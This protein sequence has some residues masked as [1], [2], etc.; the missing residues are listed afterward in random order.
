MKKTIAIL[1][2]LCLCIG[3]CACGT[4]ANIEPADTSGV[5]TDSTEVTSETTDV[6]SISLGET[7]VALDW[8]F[9]LVDVQFATD[10]GNDDTYEN[11]YVPGGKKHSTNPYKLEDDECFAVV[12][13]KVR[14]I[15]KE[16][17]RAWDMFQGAAIGTGK[18]VYG[19]GYE[20]MSDTTGDTPC[21]NYYNGTKFTDMRDLYCE[22]LSGEVECR[23]LF[24]LPKT[25]T[26]GEDSLVYQVDFCE[27][28]ASNQP[29]N[30]F[31]VG[32]SKTVSYTIR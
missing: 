27:W 3:L 20:F 7:V 9:T 25:V 6:Q 23:V 4:D 19:D 24:C 1:L 14:N 10:V 12:T 30:K 29:G 28:V 22:P 15:G 31:V 8:E 18:F 2:V 16:K 32:E 21:A 13:Y 5:V 26:E 11:F 17:V